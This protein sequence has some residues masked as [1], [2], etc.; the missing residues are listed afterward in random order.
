MAGTVCRADSTDVGA[1]RVC[2]CVPVCA[3]CTCMIAQAGE[4]ACSC[5]G[6]HWL[7]EALYTLARS[8]TP[9]LSTNGLTAEA[10]GAAL[11]FMTHSGT[12]L[13]MIAAGVHGLRHHSW[14]PSRASFSAYTKPS[15]AP[16]TA[17]GVLYRPPMWSSNA[18]WCL[19]S[20]VTNACSV[21]F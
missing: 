7:L 8:K 21:L 3:P 17:R 19:R 14:S 12:W 6:G 20:D 5:M 4:P 16:C 11:A 15:H 2:V 13:G 10:A 1:V 9:E 18:D